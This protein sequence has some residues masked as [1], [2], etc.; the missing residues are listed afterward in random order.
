MGGIMDTGAR[1]YLRYLEGDDDGIAE[2]VR[3]YREGLIFFLNGYVKNILTAEELTEDTF[4]K[5]MIKKPKFRDGASFKTWLY[6]IGKNTALDY[7]RKNSR[8]ARVS[9]EELTN[10]ALEQADFERGLVRDEQR[11]AI[12]KAMDKLPPQYRQVLH[13][14]FFEEFD[15]AE[16]AKILKKSKRQIEMLTYRA[17]KA[18]KDQLEKEGFVYED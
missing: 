10:A 7:I 13:L 4:F 12:H 16:S 3:E 11:L 2:I 17:K 9:E 8:H 15:N 1:N 5:I 6:T 18:L 14:I